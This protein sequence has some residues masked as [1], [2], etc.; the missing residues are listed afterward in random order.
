MPRKTMHSQETKDKISKALSKKIEF[1]CNM[2]GKIA[3][4]KPSHYK[5]KKTPL[6]LYELLF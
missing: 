3:Y 2:C 6:L 5:R 1:K 4:D